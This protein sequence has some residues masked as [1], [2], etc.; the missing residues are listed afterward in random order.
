MKHISILALHQVNMV[1]LENARQGL[2]EVN[3]YCVNQGK[4]PMFKVEIVG[5]QSSIRAQG[6]LYTIHPDRLIEEV[7]HTDIIIIPPVAPAIGEAIKN[8]RVYA[9]W[10]V[11]NYMRGAQVMSLCMGAFILADTGLLANRSCVTHWRAADNF[12][13]MYPEVNLVSD[14]LLT[15]EDRIYTGAGAFSSVNLVLYLIEKLAGREAAVYC[16]KVF[17]VDVNRDSQSPFIIF[18]GQKS[19][20]DE[21]IIKTQEYIEENY[22]ESITVAELCEE[23]GIGRRTLERRFKKATANTLIEY[24]QRIR[25]EAAKKQ[26]EAGFKTINEIMYD[27]GYNDPKAFRAVFKKITGMTPADYKERFSMMQNLAATA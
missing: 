5:H 1:G 21:D 15:D 9:P 17:Q 16:S 2:S 23:F 19:H 7:T 24:I 11:Q 3:A 4:P 6:G 14:K 25:A 10:I 13:T 8:N 27:V 20:E 18:E 12:R 22:R 26:L